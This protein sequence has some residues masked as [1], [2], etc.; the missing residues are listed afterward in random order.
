MSTSNNEMDHKPPATYFQWRLNDS[1][2]KIQ[3]R[4]HKLEIR[5]DIL[6]V[7][8]ILKNQGHG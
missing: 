7:L 4:I 8:S 6:Q 3:R 2:G 1:S 5:E